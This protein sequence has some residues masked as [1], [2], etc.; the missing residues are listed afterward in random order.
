MPT[1]ARRVRQVSGYTTNT[2]FSLTRTVV[3]RADPDRKEIHIRVDWTDRNDQLQGVE[4]NSIIAATD[5][6]VSLLLTA[7]PN[8][9]P[10][11][12]PLGRHPGIPQPAVSVGPGIS[13]FKPPSGSAGVVWVFNN[14]SGVIVGVCNNV[15]TEQSLLTAADVGHLQQQRHRPAPE[16]LRALRHRRPASPLPPTPRTRLSTALNLSIDLDLTSTGHPLPDHVCFA[17]APIE[18]RRRRRSCP[19]TAPSSPMRSVVWSGRSALTPVAF[20]TPTGLD[21]WEIA[22]DAAD[23]AASHYRVCRYT[24]AGNDAQS[25][26]NWQH[27]R[28]YS[29][30]TALTPLYNQNFL[31][32]RAG[33]G[34][35]PFSCPPTSSPT[36]RQATSS[37]ATRWCTSPRPSARA[38]RAN[39]RAVRRRRVSKVTPACIPPKMRGT[40]G[41]VA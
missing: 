26:Q 39:A 21:P 36:R 29:N 13:A 7:R 30:V 25:I 24:P 9:I 31:V 37:T 28:N 5:P 6:R 15:A 41:Y 11:R 32:I 16:R 40:Q 8:G 23:A 14:L 3:S 38:W 4:L 34:V 17:A 19:I 35:Q 20:T 33:D 10:E 27:P 1:S 12:A 22:G 2:T 18:R